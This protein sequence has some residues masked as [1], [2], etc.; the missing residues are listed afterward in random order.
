MTLNPGSA[1]GPYSISAKIGEGGMGEVYQARDTKL[2]RDVALKVLP[3]AFTADPD[4]LARFE[5]EA[6][7]ISSL[8]HPHICTLHD[9]GSQK[10]STGSGEA[11]IDFLVMEYLEGDTLAQRLEKG[12]L[13]LDQALKVA[14]EIADALDKAHRQGIV[15]RDLKPGNIMLTKAGAKLLDFGLAKLRPKRDLPDGMSAP[16]MTEGLT[17]EGTIVG[18]LQYMAPEQLEGKEADHRT[19]IFAFGAIVYEMVTGERAFTGNSQASLIGAI[20]K[21]H[22]VAI[23][24]VQSISPPAL[25][26]LVGVCLAEDPEARWQSAGDV[27]RQLQGLAATTTPVSGTAAA[28]VVTSHRP[29]WRVALPW[30]AAALIIGAGTARLVFRGLTPASPLPVRQFTILPPDGETVSLSSGTPDIAIS[31]DGR[32]VVYTASGD[33]AFEIYVQS[34]DTPAPRRL[35]GPEGRVLSPVVSPDNNWVAFYDDDDQSLQKVAL[36]GGPATTLSRLGAIMLSADWVDNDTIV[37]GTNLPSGL[38]RVPAGGGEPESLTTPD[39]VGDRENHLWP[40]VL[41]DRRGVLFT[42][43]TGSDAT[44]A[45]IAHLDLDTGDIRTVLPTGT[46]PRYAVPGHLLY[47]D[48]GTVQAVGF[49]L[50][51]LEVDG[52]RQ[53]TVLDG[54]V[55]K[56]NGAAN[57]D[58][59]DDGSLVYLSGGVSGRSRRLFWVDRLGRAEDIDWA[60]DLLSTVR[61]SPDG[62]RLAA[63]LNAYGVSVLAN[64]QTIRVGSDLWGFDLTNGSSW[65]LTSTPGGDDNAVWT[66]DGSQ[67]FWR[68]SRDGALGDLFR[69]PSDGTGQEERLTSDSRAQS[70]HAITSDGTRLVFGEDR[71]ETGADIGVLSL[72]T[73]ERPPRWLLE[74]PFHER[75]AALSPDDRW[76]AY[77]S[78]RSGQEEVYV[79][80]FPNLDDGLIPVSIGGGSDPRWGPGGDEIFYRSPQGMMAAQ[81]ATTPSFR[82]LSRDTLFEESNTDRQRTGSYDVGPDGRFLIIRQEPVRVRFV[83]NWLAELERLVPVN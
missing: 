3:E 83:Q 80:P 65:R 79:G 43:Q 67:I 75:N 56:P 70:P 48:G 49:D 27:G 63:S 52:S 81:V 40:H 11:E 7:T 4:R 66:P 77:A 30:A 46:S 2:D 58:I 37:L 47:A 25:D 61:L 26:R 71:P 14:I 1:L 22:P 68:A 76:M 72:S 45:R 60:P 33:N 35:E 21:D 41:P 23:S 12:A 19:D 9:I 44:S 24:V 13:P 78:D 34:L 73:D 54:L 28:A 16:T 8:N 29:A 50:D 69:R 17:G 39:L 31:P 6:K 55:T 59:A 82:V 10:P 18:T 64:G 36:G 62:E 57:F 53:A 20:L 74:T 15:H 32:D 42:V 5:R 51:T 38:W